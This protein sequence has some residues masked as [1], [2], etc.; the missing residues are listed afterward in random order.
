MALLAACGG[1]DPSCP[2]DLPSSCPSPTPSYRN[3]V[4]PIIAGRCLSC[5]APGGQEA[6]RPLTTYSQVF[7][8]RGPILT[9]I[10]ACRMPPAGSAAPSP[11]ERTLLL[12]W[13][14]CGAPDN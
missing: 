1:Q 5:H 9:Q 4:A 3:E 7:S 8:N 2:N 14:V 13:L 12:G 11:Q 6:A 10:F